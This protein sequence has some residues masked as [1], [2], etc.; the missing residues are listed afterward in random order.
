[1]IKLDHL[2]HSHSL[3]LQ[4]LDI[5]NCASLAALRGNE[6]GTIDSIAFASFPLLAAAWAALADILGAEFRQITDFVLERGRSKGFESHGGAPGSTSC[7]SFHHHRH[8]HHHHHHRLTITKM[9]PRMP[10]SIVD[11]GTILCI[12]LLHPFV[13]FCLCAHS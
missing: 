1:M 2:C 4:H 5:S 7:Q 9:Y 10:F 13:L 8:H 11:L 12:C 3:V 6:L